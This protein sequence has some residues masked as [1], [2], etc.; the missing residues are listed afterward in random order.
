MVGLDGGGLTF[1]LNPE[2]R[3]TFGDV[4]SV[5]FKTMRNSGILLQAAGGDGPCLSLELHR[6]RLQLLLLRQGT[7]RV[8]V[9]ECVL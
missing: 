1:R 6:G 5:K 9:C 7:A 3:R 2:P 8:C 4:L